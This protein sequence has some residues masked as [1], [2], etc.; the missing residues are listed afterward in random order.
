M[1]DIVTDNASFRS[2]VYVDSQSVHRS[3]KGYPRSISVLQVLLVG[4]SGIGCELR[5]YLE[6]MRHF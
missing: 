4:A 1:R 5:E 3:R 6:N 2:P